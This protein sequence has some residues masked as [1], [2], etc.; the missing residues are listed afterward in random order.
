MTDDFPQII[1]E[2]EVPAGFL[3]IDSESAEGCEFILDSDI[4]MILELGVLDKASDVKW[5]SEIRQ[6]ET[7][8]YEKHI[9]GDLALRK[10]V[11]DLMRSFLLFETYL[12]KYSRF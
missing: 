5:R 9:V 3:N 7:A 8:S 6:R 1:C 4:I 11:Q 2:K 10:V 12:G